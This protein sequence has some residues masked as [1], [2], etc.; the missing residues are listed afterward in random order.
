M[1]FLVTDRETNL[2]KV[3]VQHAIS[4]GNM[5]LHITGHIIHWI[6]CN[7]RHNILTS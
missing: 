7:K 3:E 2:Q 5:P 4:G 6:K 1:S